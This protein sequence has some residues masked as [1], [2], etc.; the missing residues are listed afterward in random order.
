MNGRP[1]ALR[2][3]FGSSS[4]KYSAKLYLGVVNGGGLLCLV[5]AATCSSP[6]WLRDGALVKP[7]DADFNWT[8]PWNSTLALFSTCCPLSPDF[9]VDA[10][11]K[12]EISHEH[13][14]GSLLNYRIILSKNTPNEGR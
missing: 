9:Y 7:F 14:P 11:S 12:S 2:D 1:R 6:V 4:K 8:L 3:E 5:L 13:V 10:Q